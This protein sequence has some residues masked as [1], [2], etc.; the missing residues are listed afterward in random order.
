M[1]ILIAI[2]SCHAHR[3]QNQLI[4]NTWLSGRTVPYRFFLGQGPGE[5]KGDEVFLPCGDDYASLPFKTQEIMRWALSEGYDFVFKCDT[6]TYVCVPRLL[7]SGFEPHDY[8]GCFATCKSCIPTDSGHCQCSSE[9]GQRFY[10]YASGGAGYWLSARA[11][12]VVAEAPF[13]LDPLVPER[14][15]PSTRGEDL[16]V[17]WALGRQGI[18]C[19]RDPRFSL[20][21]PGP[22]RNNNVITLHDVTRL[23]GTQ[24]RLPNLHRGWLESGGN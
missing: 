3:P 16:Q 9:T 8:V 24:D 7:V 13:I 6:D 18:L 5:P 19:Y 4:R 2:E 20:W 11:M 15:E 14:D 1:N 10:S 22:R 17:G 12:R 23:I 21:W